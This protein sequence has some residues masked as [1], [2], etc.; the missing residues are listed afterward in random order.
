[1]KGGGVLDE[2]VRERERVGRCWCT[3]ELEERGSGD[4]GG[5]KAAKVEIALMEEGGKEREVGV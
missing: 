5:R 4:G 1:M 2:E 3:L